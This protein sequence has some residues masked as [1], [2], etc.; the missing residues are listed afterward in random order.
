MRMALARIQIHICTSSVPENPVSR[1]PTISVVLLLLL[2]SSRV[3]SPTYCTPHLV[4]H[5]PRQ[6]VCNTA[7]LQRDFGHLPKATNTDNHLQAHQLSLQ[8]FETPSHKGS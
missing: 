4:N 8:W 6:V 5:E 7:A 3:S 2:A 1:A